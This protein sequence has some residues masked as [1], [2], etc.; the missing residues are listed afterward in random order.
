MITWNIKFIIPEVKSEVRIDYKRE[1]VKEES[2]IS[3]EISDTELILMLNCKD[4]DCK[5][6][7]DEL[8]HCDRKNIL[9]EEIKEE[10][11]K[12]YYVRSYKLDFTNK[13]GEVKLSYPKINLI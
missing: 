8:F 4:A 13:T 12:E 7:N 6:C 10:M 2:V 3:I 1:I 9:K 5:F 11:I